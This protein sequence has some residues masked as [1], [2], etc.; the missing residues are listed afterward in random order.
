MGWRSSRHPN[1]KIWTKV[2]SECNLL[3]EIPPDSDGG[4]CLM[5]PKRRFPLEFVVDIWLWMK[6]Q[7]RF[8][9][10]SPSRKSL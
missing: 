3:Q 5:T 1:L 8:A 10:Q 4:V 2:S 9:D 7:K 6:V